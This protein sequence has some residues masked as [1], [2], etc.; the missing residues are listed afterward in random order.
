[1]SLK[2]SRQQVRRRVVFGTG[3]IALD[4]V[5]SSDP[6]KPVQAWTG[7]TCGN[8]LSILSFLGWNAY[9]IARLNGDTA[10]LRVKAD[11]R[12]WGVHLDFAQCEPTTS[13][14][15][16]VQENRLTKKG[17]PKHHFVWT[18]PSCGSDLPKFKPLPLAAAATV[19]DDVSGANVF[20]L[21]RISRA[22]VILAR[23]AA[24]AG[25]IIVVEPSGKSPEKLLV[26]A[27]RIAHVVKY[28]DQRI[29]SLDNVGAPKTCAF[30]EVQTLGEKGLRYRSGL[31]G[32][33]TASWTHLP[34]YKPPRLLDTC[35]AGDWTTAGLITQLCGFGL[36][37][38][39]RVSTQ[40]IESALRYAQA[41]AAWSCGHEGARG[42]MY[43]VTRAD[44]ERCV[45]NF[46]E[47]NS[48]AIALNVP[49]GVVKGGLEPREPICPACAHNKHKKRSRRGLTIA[50]AS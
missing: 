47:A 43:T 49:C 1:M 2:V 24:E 3:L 45:A 23:V 19:L 6:N 42:G 38:L 5:V 33:R 29:D 7:G 26:E 14:P 21:D 22:G 35:G 30:L 10:S 11:L 27:L 17:H 34:G 39:K 40:R 18:C 8:V 31:P 48:A 20:F 37:T 50:H 36:S 13:T 16:I 44:F 28:S 15:M 32:S 12:S 9:P 25:A 41:A 46:L 4:L